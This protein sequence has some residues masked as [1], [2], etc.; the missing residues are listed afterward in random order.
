[1]LKRG[2]ELLRNVERLLKGKPLNPT[3]ESINLYSDETKQAENW[4]DKSFHTSPRWELIAH[5]SQYLADRIPNLPDVQRLITES[6]VSLRG[7]P[8]PYIGQRGESVTFN[9]GFQGHVNWN[10]MRETFRF[11]KSGLF[12]WKRA[13]R[14]DLRDVKP[15]KGKRQLSFIVA[16]YSLTE[17]LLFLE[18]LYGSI[19]ATDTVRILVRVVGCKNRQLASF[20][21]SV[22]FY[23]DWYE[24]QEDVIY[25]ER[26]YTVE[27]LRASSKE[28]A[29]VIAKHIFHVFNWTDVKDEMIEVWQNKLLN[30][31]Y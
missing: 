28:I 2:D 26:D 21:A 8:F 1:M 24:S 19:D 4:F 17:W 9:N 25:F 22:P 18:R 29:R 11:Y 27:E 7:W 5:P 13:I 30:R 10:D 6:Q 15:D 3:E 20:D 16:I 12:V 31:T 23:S 14:E